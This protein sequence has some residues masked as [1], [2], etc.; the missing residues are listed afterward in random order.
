M[1]KEQ[2]ETMR[3]QAVLTRDE[4][5]D[6]LF[7]YA[8]RSTGIYC[9]PSCPSR[10]PH[11][12][13]VAFYE[14]P[15]AAE[16]AGFRPCQRCR[17]D[18]ITPGHPHLQLIQAVCRHIQTHFDEPLTLTSL[19]EQFATSP[20]HLQ[21]VFTSVV[22]IS[23]LQYTEECRMKH[24]KQALKNGE[25]ITETI[26]SAGFGSSSRLYTKAI[27][28]LGMT[29]RTYQK[30]GR[31]ETIFYT[32]VACRLGYL[33]VAATGRGICAV[34]LGDSEAELTQD[35]VAEFSQATLV[36]DDQELQEWV[37]SIL[38]YLDG[39]QPHLNLP[40]DIQAT[41]FQK[42]VWQALQAIP[43]GQTR[44]YSQV[45]QAI[46]RPDAVRAVAH[47]CATNPTALV[48]PCHRVVRNDGHLA[49]YRWG[50]PRKEELLRL[51]GATAA[52]QE[53]FTWAAARRDE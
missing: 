15:E 39:R 36:H 37:A 44:T 16:R 23:P 21:R 51:E 52:A 33:V 32:T 9:R 20:S 6:G 22:G 10:K 49:G 35:L 47:A 24:V 43:Y 34:R 7:V 26:Y 30:G 1:V 40:L 11:R 19:G 5:Y 12:E 25:P 28:Q 2:D 18:Q 29:P 17:S 31:G 8:V 14:L 4:N 48:I 45:A 41:A 50:L 3:W 27:P 42:Q 13:Q 53:E 38:G 46:G